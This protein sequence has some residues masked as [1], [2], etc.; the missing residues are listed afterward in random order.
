MHSELVC[1]T[2]FGV[3]EYARFALFLLYHVEMSY[4][5]FAMC[6]AYDLSGTIIGVEYQRKVYHTILLLNNAVENSNIL[7]FYFS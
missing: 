5:L 7:F 6:M 3:K 1:T 2:G 4:C